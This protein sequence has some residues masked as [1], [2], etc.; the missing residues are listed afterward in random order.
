M[1]NYS[2]SVHEILQVLYEIAT[3]YG[4]VTKG[5]SIHT[6]IPRELVPTT[7]KVKDIPS[8]ALIVEEGEN[9]PDFVTFER[10]TLGGQAEVL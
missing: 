5:F 3:A 9:S 8:S 2:E 10:E 1:Q 4:N 6:I 7:C